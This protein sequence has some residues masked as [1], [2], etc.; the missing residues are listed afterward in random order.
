MTDKGAV[1][2]VGQ[3]ASLKATEQAGIA[4]S[5]L[6][7]ASAGPDAMLA[8]VRMVGAEVIVG[9]PAVAHHG[10]QT[11]IVKRMRVTSG[12]QGMLTVVIAVEG[13][14]DLGRFVGLAGISVDV[15]QQELP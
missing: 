12:K 4:V 9:L 7:L 13:M 11:G 5:V 6:S 2:W 10:R 8:A 14:R 1:S 3:R 15:R